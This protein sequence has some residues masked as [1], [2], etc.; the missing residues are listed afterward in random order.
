[1]SSGKLVFVGDVHLEPD[2]PA[3]GAFLSFLERLAGFASRVV[4][5]GD[6]FPI[7]IGQRKLERP[8]QRLVVERLQALRRA[9]VEVVYVEG[10]RDFR[11]RSAYLG[12][13]FDAVSEGEFAQPW[14]GRTWLAIHGD[15]A[16]PRDRL[17][18]IW[19]RVARSGAAWGLFRAL[20]PSRR[21]AVAAWLERRLR[22]ANPNFKGG[23]PE[24][25]VRAYAA[26]RLARGYDA[27]VL[28]HFHVERFF[29]VEGKPVYVLPEW[30]QSRRLLEVSREGKARFCDARALWGRAGV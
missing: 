6:L 15:L 27:L 14:A 12:L 30:R 29:E 23:L 22:E 28:G 20:P 13:A 2:D 10:N 3:G 17:Y 26:E 4:L 11:I 18:R 7:W 25:T 24:T 9:G 21:L 5:L 8:H 1:M 19:R 16:N